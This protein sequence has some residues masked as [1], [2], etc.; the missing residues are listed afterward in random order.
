VHLEYLPGR[1]GGWRTRKEWRDVLSGGEK[2]RV[3]G[4]TPF[5]PLYS[6]FLGQMAMARVFYHRPKYA[7]L[8]GELVLVDLKKRVIS[9]IQSRVHECCFERR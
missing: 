4:L 5:P 6:H 1:E 9:D 2:Q 8:D 3:R 7:V